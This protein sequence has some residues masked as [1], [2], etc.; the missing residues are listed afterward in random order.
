MKLRVKVKGKNKIQKVTIQ[1]MN[2][3][4]NRCRCADK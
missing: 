1:E 4:T 3:E 2:Y